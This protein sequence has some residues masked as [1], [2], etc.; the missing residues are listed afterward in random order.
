M[1]KHISFSHLGV[2]GVVV[3]K[4]K[5]LAIKKAKGPYK[6]KYDLPGGGLEDDELILEALAREF[7]EE[8]GL[9][10]KACW[11]LRT[12]DHLC[13]CDYWI[14]PKEERKCW[15]R[16]VGMVYEVELEEGEVK[17]DG[18]GNDSLGCEWL[19]MD[20]V[21][22]DNSSPFLFNAVGLFNA[23]ESVKKE[24]GNIANFLLKEKVD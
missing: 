13:E 5:V 22:L 2:Y 19:D 17:K 8:V 4:N 11:Q 16:H 23:I 9:K 10:V 15:F 24:G 6:G 21:N 7:K 20:S 18:D 12:F 3:R 14:D 1:S